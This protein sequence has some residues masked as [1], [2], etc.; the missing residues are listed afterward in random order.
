GPRWSRQHPLQARAAYGRAS[1]EASPEGRRVRR[2]L[3]ESVHRGAARLLRRDQR[4][5]GDAR[6]SPTSV[7][8]ARG[9]EGQPAE[10]EAREYPA[11]KLLVANRGEIALRIFRACRDLGI[12]T[13]A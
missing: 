2:E 10:E 6:G 12:R 1:G 5:E 13:V 8:A 3:R 7:P 4:A 11:V 9:Q